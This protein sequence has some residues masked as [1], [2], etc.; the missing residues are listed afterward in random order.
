MPP[1]RSWFVGQL[2]SVTSLMGINSWSD[3]KPHVVKVV[4]FEYFCEPPFRELWDEV[5]AQ[6]SALDVADLDPW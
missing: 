3:M 2:V 4:W 1:E 6:R 5:A